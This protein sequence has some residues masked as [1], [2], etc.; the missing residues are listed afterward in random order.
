LVREGRIV[1]RRRTAA[2]EVGRVAR[3]EKLVAYGTVDGNADNRVEAFFLGG[4]FAIRLDQPRKSARRGLKSTA[5][6]IPHQRNG[7][8]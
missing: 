3:T 6:S 4:G 7:R 2:V 8:P 5:R 1:E